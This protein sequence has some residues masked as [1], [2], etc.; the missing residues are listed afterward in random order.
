MF[1]TNNQL[2]RKQGGGK[3][4]KQ[5]LHRTR[6]GYRER[7]SVSP[8]LEK[9]SYNEILLILSTMT[10]TIKQNKTE[11]PPLFPVVLLLDKNPELNGT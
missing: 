7:Y 6:N 8:I 4:S 9:Q 5:T 2:D 11:N 1:Y 10:P 3:G